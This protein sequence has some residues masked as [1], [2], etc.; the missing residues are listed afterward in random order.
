MANETSKGGFEMLKRPVRDLTCTCLNAPNQASCL[1]CGLSDSLARIFFSAH[2]HIVAYAREI[3]ASNLSRD[4]STGSCKAIGIEATEENVMEENA[5]KEIPL[6]ARPPPPEPTSPTPRP[7]QQ[8]TKW[9]AAA[10][11][12]ASPPTASASTYPIVPT[13]LPLNE[14]PELQPPPTARAVA[15]DV[16]LDQSTYE[17]TFPIHSGM[18][19]LPASPETPSHA[20]RSHVSPTL[21]SQPPTTSFLPDQKTNTEGQIYF[22]LSRARCKKYE[23]GERRYQC[24]FQ[25][26][27][28]LYVTLNHLNA[29][30][31]IKDT[32]QN[33][34]RKELR[35]LW[36]EQQKKQKEAEVHPGQQD[37]GMVAEPSAPH[38]QGFHRPRRSATKPP[39]MLLAK[40]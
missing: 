20:S 39:P 4:T 18:A 8:P 38:S 11:V 17:F 37:D 28:K 30:V 6:G 31:H 35:K 15:E 10:Y 5:T 33:A 34:I 27:S 22:S 7:E 3:P 1:V 26:C 29:H 24:N 14:M 25:G 40:L 21:T 23:H 16:N 19:P 32:A 36:R 9:T 2:A 13:L 12:H